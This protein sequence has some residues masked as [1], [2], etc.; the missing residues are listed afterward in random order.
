MLTPSEYKLL[1]NCFL[2][3]E[4]LKTE[5]GQKRKNKFLASKDCKILEFSKGEII[6]DNNENSNGLGIL[7][8]GKAVA[9]CSSNDKGSLKIFGAGEVFGAASVFCEN[10]KQ[11]FARVTANSA[12]RVLFITKEGLKRFL[13]ENPK[14]AFAYITFLSS[15]VEF[16]NRRIKTFTSSQAAERLCKYILENEA[17]LAKVNFASL[18]R[19]LDISRAS[20]YRARG[21]LEKTGAVEFGP[22]NI[23][24]LNKTELI[25]VL[26]K[27]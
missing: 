4:D 15:R 23:K 25:K 12:C 16:L 14:T 8:R 26:N 21:E 9:A 1:E 2:F 24:I 6:F 3:S 10:K 22:K 11:S 17:A 19:T 13:M 5:E 18:A 7:L 27:E 20:L